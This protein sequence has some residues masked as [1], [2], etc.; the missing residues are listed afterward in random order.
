MGKNQTAEQAE[1]DKWET[2]SNLENPYS[3]TGAFPPYES[4]LQRR[5]AKNPIGAALECAAQVQQTHDSFREELY[6]GLQFAYAIARHLSTDFNAFKEFYSLSFFQNG[7]RK[8]KVSKQHKNALRHVMNF[9]FNATSEV[10]R[11][12]T[13]KYA[14]ALGGYMRQGMPAHIVAEQ[15]KADGGIEKLYEISVELELARAKRVRGSSKGPNPDFLIDD[16]PVHLGGK[17][18]KT[19]DQDWSLDGLEDD[20]GECTNDPSEGDL[21]DDLVDY[22]HLGSESETEPLLK[23]GQDPS[24]RET[25]MLEVTPE[26][27]KRLLS[28]KAGQ[29]VMIRLVGMGMEE[30]ADPDEGWV[31]LRA[32]RAFRWPAGRV[33]PSVH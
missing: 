28:V 30:S 4:K 33:K 21:K 22:L 16:E 31:R 19:P 18:R 7:K 2:I 5:I 24:G 23:Q 8:F 29:L 1:T 11:K 9:V 17:A 10:A 25:I 14:A 32:R 27:K 12:R 6:G 26:M 15:I 13:G 3:W 20:P